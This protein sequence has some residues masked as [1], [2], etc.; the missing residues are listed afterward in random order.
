MSKTVY[1]VEFFKVAVQEIKAALGALG[2]RSR[3]LLILD[4]D[5]TLWGGIVGD[6]GWENLRLG[7]HDATGEAFVD[8]QRQLKSLRQRGILLGIVSKNTE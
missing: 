7:G 5:D 1:T 3:K 6:I 4:L 8:F 2:G